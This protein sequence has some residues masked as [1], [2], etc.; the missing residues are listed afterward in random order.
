M[1][2]ASGH[3]HVINNSNV[4]SI[5]KDCNDLTMFL[6][7]S[8]KWCSLLLFVKTTGGTL[9]C[10]IESYSKQIG[11]GHLWVFWCLC[12]LQV[13]VLFILSAVD[14]ILILANALQPLNGIY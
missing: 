7:L 13:K 4:I 6:Y 8:F 2:G 11:Y 1:I 9:T 5:F 12:I 10:H 3:Y 14:L